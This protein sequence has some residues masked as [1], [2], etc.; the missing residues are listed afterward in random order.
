MGL[1][2][3][4]VLQSL[5]K[6]K[7]KQ[8]AVC[9]RVFLARVG[10]CEPAYVRG[11]CQNHGVEWWCCKTYQTFSRLFFVFPAALPAHTLT[12]THSLTHSSAHTHTR[13]THQGAGGETSLLWAKDT[14]AALKRIRD[15]IKKIKPTDA[16]E[17]VKAPAEW[18][19][20]GVCWSG[21]RLD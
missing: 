16:C 7:K 5:P 3:E 9:M 14:G 8:P 13:T 21:F 2:A 17:G 19:Q 15:G 1:V 11:T 20:A 12:H 4:R 6:R 10:A 18:G